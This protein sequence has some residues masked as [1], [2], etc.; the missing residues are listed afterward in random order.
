MCGLALSEITKLGRLGCPQCYDHFGPELKHFLNS[1]HGSL[2]H[3]GKVP[4][5]FKI[6]KEMP[7]QL[8]IEVI[9]KGLESKMAKAVRDE[10][11][12]LAAEIRDA[13]RKLKQLNVTLDLLKIEFENKILNGGD[14][15]SVKAKML[16]LMNE[17]MTIEEPFT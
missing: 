6:K 5:K 4:S 7:Q 16:K 13:I 12:E 2:Q 11:Y 3:V 14:S 17:V 1:S 8:P 10:K 9:V 15:E